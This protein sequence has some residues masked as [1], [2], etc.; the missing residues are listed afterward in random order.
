[1]TRILSIEHSPI[2]ISLT[3]DDDTAASFAPIWIRESC[4]CEMCRAPG[5]SFRLSGL[6]DL[7][8]FIEA[9]TVVTDLDGS[10]LSCTW[11]DGHQTELAAEWLASQRTTDSFTQRSAARPNA[12]AESPSG[13]NTASKTNTESKIKSESE[14]GA[15]DSMEATSSPTEPTVE[16][17]PTPRSSSGQQPWQ[18]AFEPERSDYQ[19]LQ[20]ENGHRKWLA[21]LWRDGVS[22]VTDMPANRAE[23]TSFANR[24][25]AVQPS[26]YGPDWEIEASANPTTRVYSQD[27][28]AVHTD[29]PYRPTPPGVQFNLSEIA[30]AT[31]GKA[32]VADG[33][34]VANELRRVD[35][36]AFRLLTTVDFELT[37]LDAEHDLKHRAPTI[38]VDH[39]G[40][41]EMFR[42][43]PGLVAPICA[44]PATTQ[45]AHRAYQQ[46]TELA[47][48]SRFQI[49]I[50]LQPGDLLAMNNHRVLHGRQAF[51]LRTGRRRLI[52]CY[53][54][55]NDLKRIV[56][57]AEPPNQR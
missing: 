18:G 55:L 16:A 23:L 31:G 19:D 52:G 11:P 40:D 8:S 33:I 41:Y 26:N 9:T 37:W 27:G 49:A 14:T 22:I 32:T 56:Q 38:T 12:D 17:S 3:F 54:D 45:A 10:T 1:M 30:D 44:D 57:Q 13:A 24:I 47:A 28:L 50:Q 42:Y 2:Q 25:G 6:R 21:G 53:L 39:A 48:E 7:D 36:E 20:T 5:T 51:D 34:A 4:V 43:A 35:P 46:F 15:K 29:I